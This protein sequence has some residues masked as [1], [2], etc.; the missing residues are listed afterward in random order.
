M[1]EKPSALTA[2]NALQAWQNAVGGT[3]RGNFGRLVVD[4]GQRD[5][6]G[7]L[8]APWPPVP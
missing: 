8:R 1:P 5:S 7:G 3:Q 4:L 2:A 6:P